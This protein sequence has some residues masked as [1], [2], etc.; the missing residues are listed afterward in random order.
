MCHCEPERSEG[1][2]NLV[3][4]MIFLVIARSEATKQS[5]KKAMMRL[6][7]ALRA[8]AM[9]DKKERGLGRILSCVIASPSEAKGEAIL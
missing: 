5:H 9:T 7:R 4:V 1:R 8:L 6:P 2:S 3:I